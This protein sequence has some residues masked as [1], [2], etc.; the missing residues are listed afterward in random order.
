[1]EVKNDKN[2]IESDIYEN[3]QT[4]IHD[5]LSALDLPELIDSQ[6]C[7]YLENLFVD[8]GDVK[9]DE[10]QKVFAGILQE[11][12]SAGEKEKA[13]LLFNIHRVLTEFSGYAAN[14][15]ASSDVE[16]C[17]KEGLEIPET[18]VIVVDFF[19]TRNLPAIVN[20]LEE[21]GIDLGRIRVCV[22]KGILAVQLMQ[23]NETKKAEFD[24]AC[25]KLEEEQ[26]VIED[27]G[28]NGDIQVDEAVAVWFSPRT[29]PI[30]PRLHAETEGETIQNYQNAFR[31]RADQ[32]VQGG[33]IYANLAYSDDW[34]PLQVE[35]A[36]GKRILTKLTGISKSVAVAI[37]RLLTDRLAF[38]MLGKDEFEPKGVNA[39]IDHAKLATEL[40]VQKK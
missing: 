5:D 33:R 37:A 21:R 26:F 14:D 35:I 7:E 10:H 40:H 15:K 2:F 16:A 23:M 30:Y 28:H 6:F 25:S 17:F 20:V 38:G 34:E 29:M 9:A 31:A 27:V 22:P 24:A 39:E 8:E 1:M 11:L 19:V 13:G 12:L 32:V 36:D 4:A 3:P 18:G